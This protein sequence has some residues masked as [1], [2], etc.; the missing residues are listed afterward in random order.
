MFDSPELMQAKAR[1]RTAEA[2]CAKY[3]ATEPLPAWST[4]K[5]PAGLVE[6]HDELE[7]ARAELKR[8]RRSG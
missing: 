7:A 6:A 8:V 1:V 4:R 2:N 3:A 5:A